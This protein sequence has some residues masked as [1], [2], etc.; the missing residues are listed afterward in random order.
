MNI[1]CFFNNSPTDEQPLIDLDLFPF[2]PQTLYSSWIEK[3]TSHN[4]E[5]VYHDKEDQ[6]EDRTD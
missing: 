2:F 3:A 5:S 4:S 6:K 1:D